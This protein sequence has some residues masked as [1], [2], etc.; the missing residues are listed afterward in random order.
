[1]AVIAV[2]HL[3]AT[4]LVFIMIKPGNFMQISKTMEPIDMKPQPELLQQLVV[5]KMPFGKYKGTVLSQLPVA[6]LEW[7]KRKGFPQG[8]LGMLLATLYEIKTNGL[9]YLLPR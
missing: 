4:A 2:I 3:L 1:M 8:K 6:Y 5:M 9:G 7:F